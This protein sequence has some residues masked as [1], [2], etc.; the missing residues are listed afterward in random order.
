MKC[1]HKSDEKIILLTRH[2][3]Q[4][5]LWIPTAS[6]HHL[7]QIKVGFRADSMECDL[8][9]LPLFSSDVP[10]TVQVA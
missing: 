3:G 4:D 1:R 10:L 8:D 7:N 5:L 6:I 9:L 2:G